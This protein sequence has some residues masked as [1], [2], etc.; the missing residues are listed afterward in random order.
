MVHRSSCQK[1]VYLAVFLSLQSRLG[2]LSLEGFVLDFE[3]AAWLAIREAFPGVE[4]KGCAFHWS[5]ACGDTFS[6]LDWLKRICD[7]RA[8]IPSCVKCWP[9][10]SCPAFTYNKQ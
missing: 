9:F 10:S 2:H 5:Q 4:I 3:K 8:F 6:Q 7:E 1:S